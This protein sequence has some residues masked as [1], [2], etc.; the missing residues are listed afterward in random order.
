MGQDPYR[1]T[2]RD[3]ILVWSGVAFALAVVVMLVVFSG[4]GTG[5]PVPFS[6]PPAISPSPGGSPVP[7]PSYDAEIVAVP[8]LKFDRKDLSV[9]S[10]K[11]NVVLFVNKDTNI[12]HNFA[13]YQDASAKDVVARGAIC[14]APCENTIE[15]PA[16]PPGRYFFK[17]D[18]H[19]QTMTGTLV[20]K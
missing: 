15:V 18:L 5:S 9:L 1:K 17:C 3:V 13:V 10:G 2:L 4:D 12:P 19:P 16:L 8:V 7:V 11:K 14:N 6:S 20:V